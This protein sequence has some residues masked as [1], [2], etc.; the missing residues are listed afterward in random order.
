MVRA[1]TAF[2]RFAVLFAAV[3]LSHGALAKPPLFSDLTFKQAAEKSRDER[4]ILIVDAMASW[5]GPCKAMDRYSW[6]NASVVRW[7]RENALAV[8]F[9]VDRDAELSRRFNISAMPT[10]IVLMGD[11]E[12]ERQVGGLEP[13]AL[14]DWL[15]SVNAKKGPGLPSKRPSESPDPAGGTTD[16]TPTDPLNPISPSD[17]KIKEARELANAG[18]AEEAAKCYAAAWTL[19]TQKSIPDAGALGALS[20][21]MGKLARSSAPAKQAFAALR[22]AAGPSPKEPLAIMPGPLA[23]WAALNDVL[24]ESKRTLEW[25]DKVKADPNAGWLVARVDRNLGPALVQA[26]RWDD[27]KLVVKA[28]LKQNQARPEHADWLG[29]AAKAGKGDAALLAEVQA[30]ATPSR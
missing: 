5:C 30:R 2:R 20:D 27:V 6:T 17:A 8:Q 24:G 3:A 29:A 13:E 23:S 11:R 25:F 9:D 21:E 4:K 18:S 15:R 19:L 22:D 16:K 14:L 28:A 26:K 12:I 1:I 7:V 10:I